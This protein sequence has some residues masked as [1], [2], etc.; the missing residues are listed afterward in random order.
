MSGKP[1]GELATP[2]FEAPAEAE[3]L[4]GLAS[5]LELLRAFSPVGSTR[6]PAAGVDVEGAVGTAKSE[7]ETFSIRV[8]GK[9][10]P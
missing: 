6:V 3:A 5:K 9:L 1:A 4:L 10:C 2:S 7:A 8:G